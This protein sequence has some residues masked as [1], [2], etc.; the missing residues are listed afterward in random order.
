M[1]FFLFLGI[2]GVANA[3]ENELSTTESLAANLAQQQ[4]EAYN[5][6]NIFQFLQPYADDIKAYNYPNVLIFEGKDKMREIYGK[7]FA[8]SPNL[9]CKLVDRTIMGNVVID[10]EKV[11][12]IAGTADKTV[13]AIAIYTIKDGKIAEVRFIKGE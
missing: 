7:M 1:I 13:E 10:Q 9:H 8:N 11:S 3:Q 5:N 6:R 4:L 12:G 2:V